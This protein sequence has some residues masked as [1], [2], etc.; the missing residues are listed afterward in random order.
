MLGGFIIALSQKI[1]RSEE[2]REEEKR[3]ESERE[4]ETLNSP[5]KELEEDWGPFFDCHF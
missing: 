3:E 4:S 1:L 2:K 5:M